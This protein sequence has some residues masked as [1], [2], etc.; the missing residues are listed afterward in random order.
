[1][2]PST[3]G[4]APILVVDANGAAARLLARQLTRAGF[5]ADVAN[6]PLGALSAASGQHYG[7]VVVVSD[8]GRNDDLEFIRLLRE[9]QPRTWVI[10]ISATA[11]ALA[12][13][14]LLR[15]G[16][17]SFLL[18]PFSMQ[19]LIGRLAAFSGHSRPG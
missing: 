5:R 3:A 4:Y 17:D 19:E 14:I 2:D 16:A 1:V 11:H 7:T 13:K 6:S 12:E 9:Q 10:A 18:A 15:C 8:A